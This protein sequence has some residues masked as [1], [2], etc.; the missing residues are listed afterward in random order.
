MS[1][2]PRNS[3]TN[4]FPIFKEIFG[5]IKNYNILDF[6][7]SSGNLLYFSQG[8]ILENSYT[9]ID[10]SKEATDKGQSEFPKARFDYYDRYNWMYNHNGNLDLKFP[11]I[12]KSYD[13]IWAYSVFS[14]TD[15]DE[16][17]KTIKWMISLNPKKIAVSFLDLELALLTYFYNK[18]IESYGYSI[19]I[20]KFCNNDFNTV[21]LFDSNMLTVNKLKLESYNCDHFVTFY[22]I[23]FLKEYFAEQDI[24]INIITPKNSTVPFL[25]IDRKDIND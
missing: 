24:Y 16:M 3:S 7:G 4:R 21:S 23:D 9:C 15:L 12:N 13:F 11:N 14:H 19:D 2:H 25:V 20:R 1:I 17:L 8:E 10:I 5:D 18:R 6:G 22:N